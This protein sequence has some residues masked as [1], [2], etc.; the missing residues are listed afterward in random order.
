MLCKLEPTKFNCEKTAA[1]KLLKNNEYINL[2]ETLFSGQ[3]FHFKKLGDG[4]FIGNV[5]N[6]FAVLKQE[7]N[8][9]YFIDY[10]HTVEGNLSKFF[11]LGVDTG[12]PDIIP[13]LRFLTN[14]ITSTIF[15]FICSSNNNISR[16]SKMVNY[17][18]SKGEELKINLP[19]DFDKNLLE[20]INLNKIYKFP[21]PSDLINCKN[22]LIMEKFGYRAQYICDAARFLSDNPIDWDKLTQEESRRFLM[23]MKGVGR[24]V[25]DCILLIGLRFFHVVPLDTHLIKYSKAEFNLSFKTMNDKIYSEIQKMWITKFGNFAGIMQLFVFKSMVDKRLKKPK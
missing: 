15:S 17:L 20:K 14:E 25:A 4:I 22:E 2:E 3:V 7:E 13:G 23:Q 16:I 10:N 18:Y 9:V 5:F 21:D 12:F 11:N 24:K 1:W 6:D 8:D 19:I